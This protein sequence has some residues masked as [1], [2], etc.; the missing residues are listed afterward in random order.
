MK[1]L[2]TLIVEDSRDDAELLL[3]HLSNGGYEVQAKIV[4]TPEDLKAALF[5]SE[6]DIILSD[7]SMPN[8]TGLGAL[9]VLKETELDIPIIIISGTIGEDVAVE[10]MVV[11]VDDYL[12]KDNL[13]RLAPAIERELEN[14]ATRRGQKKAEAALRR[15]EENLAS[16]QR[17][18]HIGSWQTNLVTNQL[19]WSDEVY[20][21]FGVSKD[22]YSATIESFFNFIHPEDRQSVQAAIDAALSQNASFTIEHRIFRPDG[23][24]RIVCGIGEV[25]LDES[26]KPLWFT[27]TVQDITER[28]HVEATLEK[29]LKRERAMIENSLDVICTIDAEGKFVSV[30]PASLKVWGY[31]PEELVGQPYEKFV[32]PE[33]VAESN[34]EALKVMSGIEANFE[35]RYLHK[36]GSI[37]DIRWT[38]F[39]SDTEQLMFCVAHDTTERKRA[40]EK[41]RESE[42]WMRAIMEGARDGILIEERSEIA[43]INKS[44]AH[45][46]GYDSAKELLGKQISDL[47]PPADAERLTEYGDRRSRGENAPSVYEFKAKHKEGNLVDVEGA[48]S[49]FFIGGREF[50]M[51]A[52]RN[53]TDRKRA[54]EEKMLLAA[55]IEQQHERL[56]SIVANVPGVVWEAWGKPDEA[57]QKIDFIS[58]Y[59]ETMLGYTN[60]EWLGTPNFWLSIVHPDDRER[61]A[62]VAAE[63]YLKSQ[64][65]TEEFR[66]VAK[67]GR[68]VWVKALSTVICDK[69]DQAIGYRGIN[70]DITERKNSETALRAAEDKYRSLVES[71]PA[72]VYLAEP[73]LPFSMIY[74]SPNISRFGYPPEEWFERPDMWVNII[75]ED[76]RARVLRTTQDAIER[77]IDTDLEYKIVTREG[78]IVWLHDKGRFVL[79]KQGNKIS[80]QGVM[81]DI[82]KTKE[83]EEQ[84]RQ[85]QKLESVGRLA[86]G[87]AHDFNNMLTAI[88]GYSDL[89]LRLLKKDDPLRGNITEIK[90]AGERS[91]LLTHQL[92]AFSRQQLLHP[93]VVDINETITDTIKIIQSLIGEDI[94]FA[95]VLDSKVGRVKV[96]PGQ[97][98]QILMNLAV[99]ARDAMPA[100]G[101][102]TIET[103]N[104][105]VEENPVSPRDGI[106]PRAYVMLSVSDNGIGMDEET[107]QKIFDPFFTTKEVG[108]GTGLGLATVYGIVKQFGGNIEVE[109]EQGVGTT[110]KIYL[111]RVMEQVESE[112]TKHASTELL[113]GTE[114]ILLVEDEEIVRNLTRQILEDCGYSVIEAR[115]GLEALELCSNGDCEIDLL[116]TDVVMPQMGGH[117]LVEKLKRKKSNLRVLIT[118]GYT[119][120]EVVRRDVI[121]SGTNFIQKPFMPKD[122]ANKI[123]EIIDNS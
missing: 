98:S 34:E 27:G 121:E 17:I 68:I 115:N 103:A 18:A 73:H 62:R 118:S 36:N 12:M 109:S 86:G 91:A 71:S 11:G 13:T 104:V 80:W 8:F 20:R 48:I 114:T 61:M 122:L 19:F 76:D 77:G 56:D 105:F 32:V 6:W 10:A 63:N 123:R 14:A 64:S 40:E 35:N 50:I 41:I 101:K 42:E 53:I 9:A 49:T 81:V 96:D 66:W 57:T 5:E 25:T 33:D 84:L 4:Q 74:V 100:G 85:A 75:H 3:R 7:Y 38:A 89:T 26:G 99:N 46:L 30:S 29:A 72:V 78:A 39:W 65:F 112:N 87:I 88:N 59:V 108:K 23:E 94:Q 67:D 31:Q 69:A 60:E 95:P 102:L 116:V 82:T 54:E 15:S 1:A 2:K 111:P 117:E 45:L 107:K 24:E 44:Y 92:L 97:M 51:T 55:Q 79:D 119:D 16:A 43:Y 28:K 37:V 22:D 83:L 120:D 47:L 90:R 93:I 21:I 106:S 52:V 70:I 58:D 110:F 113:R